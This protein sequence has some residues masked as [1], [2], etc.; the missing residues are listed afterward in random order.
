MLDPGTANEAGIRKGSWVTVGR[1][2]GQALG[3]RVEAAQSDQP[4]RCVSFAAKEVRAK[5]IA[6]TAFVALGS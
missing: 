5:V 2:A 6:A 1:A 3:E 4:P